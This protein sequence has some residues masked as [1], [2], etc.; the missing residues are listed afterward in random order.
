MLKNEMVSQNLSKELMH[1]I[2]YSNH[3]KYKEMKNRQ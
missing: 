2:G 1:E 3:L